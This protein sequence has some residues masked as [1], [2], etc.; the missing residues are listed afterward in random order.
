VALQSVCDGHHWNRRLVLV[1]KIGSPNAALGRSRG[2]GRFTIISARECTNL[3]FIVLNVV[4]LEDNGLFEVP[5]RALQTS[6][7]LNCM[8]SSHFSSL[9]MSHFG[10]QFR[11]TSEQMVTAR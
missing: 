2:A 8:S 11:M 9:S 3:V 6:D 1:V 5:N 4:V 10:A 7:S